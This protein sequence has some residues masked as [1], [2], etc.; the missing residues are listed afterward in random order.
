MA[1]LRLPTRTADS[2]N[3][4]HRPFRLPP[5]GRYPATPI[6]LSL[7]SLRY[8]QRNALEIFSQP[9]VLTLRS[10]IQAR[11]ALCSGKYRFLELPS[12]LKSEHG[13]RLLSSCLFKLLVPVWHKD[14]KQHTISVTFFR[15]SPMGTYSHRRVQIKYTNTSSSALAPCGNA[16][17]SGRVEQSE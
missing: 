9:N 4:N 16:N 7:S 13:L 11:L 14:N 12:E 1:I 8:C 2:L 17:R 10:I 3:H 15:L 5:W 6:A